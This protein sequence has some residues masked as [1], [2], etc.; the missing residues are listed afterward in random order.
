M[1]VE[2]N[3]P[4]S[5]DC[6]ARWGMIIVMT[7]RFSF[8]E[9]LQVVINNNER[10]GRKNW[11]NFSKPRKR[12]S[13]ENWNR[14]LGCRVWILRSK[15]KSQWLRSLKNQSRVS[16]LNPPKMSADFEFLLFAGERSR[17]SNSHK[18]NR[19]FTS[20]A[21]KPFSSLDNIKSSSSNNLRKLYNRLH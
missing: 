7:A 12:S 18:N 13:D 9:W 19:C 15:W 5:Y 14:I 3:L 10:V 16:I 1:C 11:R 21:D 17:N 6:I 4:R 20:H 2:F 8:W